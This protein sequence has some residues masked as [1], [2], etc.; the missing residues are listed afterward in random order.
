LQ[1]WR[2]DAGRYGVAR[3]RE[4]AARQVGSDAGLVSRLAKH[5]LNHN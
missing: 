1:Y 3:L 2:F 5:L 4:L